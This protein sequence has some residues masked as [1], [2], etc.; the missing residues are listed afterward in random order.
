MT[1]ACVPSWL[2]PVL[3]DIVNLTLFLKAKILYN[4]S[5]DVER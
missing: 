3:Y 1:R 4:R 2:W 5:H